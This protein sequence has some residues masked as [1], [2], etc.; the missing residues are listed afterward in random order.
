M[1]FKFFGGA[2]EV[3]RSSILMKAERSVMLDFGMKIDG[4]VDYPV[5]VPKID[6]LVLSHAHLDHSGACPMNYEFAQPPVFGTKPTLEL[7]ML[8]LSDALNIARKEHLPAKYHKRQLN[9]FKNSFVQLDYHR[10][11]PVG[12]V[13]LTLYDAG[14]IS[15]SAI[16]LLERAGARENKRIVYTGDL[17][18]DPQT[19]H[20]G[21]EIVKSDVLVTEATY[22]DREHP[23]REKAIARMIDEITEVLDKGGN[24]LLPSFAVGRS[25]ELLTILH[26][27]GLSG[28]TY[29][30][31]MARE[32]TK[33]VARN[34][35][36]ISNADLLSKA[37][38]DA[39]VIGSSR[40]RA[41]VLDGP[42]IIVT[43]AGMLQGGPALNYITRLN[44]NSKIFITG[45]QAE[46]T[47]GR[48]LVE[49]GH[50]RTENG[51]VRIRTPV[52]VYDLSAHASRS[53]LF[54][55]ARES[56]PNTV[57]CVHADSHVAKAFAEELRGE[58]FDAYAPRIGESIKLND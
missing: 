17:K 35:R 43:T 14:H 9:L 5:D 36:F 23:D 49:N 7:S 1:I 52:S 4:K 10:K 25:Q 40:E 44:D 29:L 48:S 54:R 39:E 21:A 38:E 32:A 56:S 2:Q 30:D 42:S 13:D 12:P 47:N 31:G 58:G 20:K 37:I 15:G 6:A 34:P 45:Y 46:D 41:S 8:L 53:G 55:Y 51:T 26:Q 50:I 3:G 24:A 18:L 19:L 33:I 28:S 22:G 16:T 27:H 11:Y 57:I